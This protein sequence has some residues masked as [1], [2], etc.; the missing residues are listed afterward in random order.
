[1]YFHL[2]KLKM[3]K[4]TIRCFCMI[5]AFFM[6]FSNSSSIVHGATNDGAASSNQSSNN[7]TS[8]Q[9]D[10]NFSYYKAY[11]QY[12]EKG[13]KPAPDGTSIV[14]D[15]SSVTASSKGDKP[16]KTDI[17]GRKE[18]AIAWDDKYD[19]FEW[20]I[21]V[22]QNGLYEMYMDY[23]PLD[24]SGSSAQRAIA[25]DGA[26][27]FDE[28][29]N[30]VFPR[31]WKE[32]GK[33]V[34]NNIGDEVWPS[35]IEDRAWKTTA[36]RD[37]QGLYSEPLQFYLSSG[38]HTIR[39]SFVDQAMAVGNITIKAPENIPTYDQVKAEYNSKGYKNASKSV[40]FQAEATVL[41][42]TDPTV[43]RVNNQDPLTEPRSIGA[44]K[45]N[46]IGDTR[47]KS[48]GQ[49]IT[50]EV[51]VPEDGLYKLDMR[52]G[53]WYNDGLPVYRQ[54]SIDGRIP[55]KEMEEYKFDYDK[56]WR[57]E[58]LKDSKGDPYLFYLTKGQHL[59][60]MNA[61]LGPLN[62]V[63]QNIM[64][65]TLMLSDIYRK[66]IMIT[67]KTPDPNYDYDL[68]RTIP[69]LT[70]DLKNLSSHMQRN[71]DILTKISSKKP[72]AANN[73]AQIK[74]QLDKMISN[75]DNI[76]KQVGD[77]ETA[78]TN[79][80]TWL[81][82]LKSIPLIMDYFVLN[83]VNKVEKTGKSNFL[84]R[85]ATTFYNFITSFGKDY[86]SI[87]SKYTKVGNEKD[88]GVTLNVWISRGKEWGEIIKEMADEDFTK[89]TGI[90]VNMNVLPAGQVNAGQAN[91]LLLSIT[92][93]KAP[94]VA[95]SL[96]PDSP[97]EFAFRDAVV[98][99]SKFSDY[100]EVAKRFYPAALTPLKYKSGVFGLPETMDFQVLFYRK[101]ILK[102]LNIQIPN[103][104]DDV[105]QKVL[106]VLYQNNLN[107]YY[108][109]TNIGLSALLFQNGGAYYNNNGTKTGLDSSV[110]YKAF[111]QWTDM[112]V[113][114]GMPVQADLYNRMRTGDTPIGVSNFAQYQY[115][116]VAAPEL[117]GRWDIAPIPG[118]KK[119]DGSIDRSNANL[120]ANADVILSQ[121]K[122]QKESWEFLKWWMSKDV[123]I[124]YGRE[125]E[126]MLGVQA[127]W[128]SANV[129]A[130]S[131]L[132]WDR[133]HLKVITEAQALSN[134]QPIVLGG[135]FTARHINNAF[136]R[137]VV[138]GTMNA[139][140]SLEQAVKDINK[141][142]K[143]KQEE[144]GYKPEDNN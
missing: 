120:L 18:N 75:P 90:H 92:S 54:I 2:T 102:Q 96:T 128:N 115:M 17:G 139:R 94:D 27:P 35:E 85:S 24:G 67:G 122:H 60:T 138:A 20:S 101:D 63:V 108:P 119:A 142:L 26:V 13:Y 113:S 40:K 131:G 129:D 103:T 5:V 22:P 46:A 53:Q 56:D 74:E 69:G 33:P 136:N 25:I 107:F 36:F 98:D 29:N 99:V 86:D 132:P 72:T 133:Q 71:V 57:I 82:D 124:K 55:F 125:L 112:Y 4:S 106:P 89:Q 137:V 68:A 59:L 10:T 37:N 64:G 118:I 87:G 16:L 45:L 80:G 66:I 23:Y 49:S 77:L 117:Y 100:D 135:Y 61:V 84:Q 143:E 78:Q 3:K 88:S 91:A 21:E 127:R 28:A 114:Y 7:S 62:D 111:K 30:I 95:L 110:A 123:Q 38:K 9:S 19:W 15:P 42:T 32:D 141:E 1:M 70:E 121:S 140:D 39:L 109:S 116:N 50:W 93:G 76:P 52:I 31:A 51:D 105:Y 6:I 11:Q 14:L 104:W 130:F 8:E 126:A 97:A 79:L 48:G 34:V 81:T 44:R 83:P 144:Y 41:N 12:K 43:R 47:W 134:E 73:F 65:D 58:T